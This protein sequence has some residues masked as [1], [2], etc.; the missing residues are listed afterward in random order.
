MGVMESVEG[1]L[2]VCSGFSSPCGGGVEGGEGGRGGGGG[3][4]KL[5]VVPR[6]RSIERCSGN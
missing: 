5:K 4:E 1:L 2:L 3:Q 6:R